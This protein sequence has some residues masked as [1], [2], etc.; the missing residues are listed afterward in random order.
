MADNEYEDNEQD[1]GSLRRQ[2][3]AALKE[4][5]QFKDQLSQFQRNDAFRQAGIDTTNGVGKLLAKAYDGDLEPD[6]IKAFAQ[7]NGVDLGG[8]SE[9]RQT[10]DTEAHADRLTQATDALRSSSRPDAT[11]QKLS[12][13]EWHALNARDTAAAR[14]AYE[15]GQV[16]IPAEIAQQLA[17]NT[18][19]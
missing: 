11:G 9:D 5:K 4:N 6:A 15:A 17:A 14:Q 12:M 2:L 18:G 10:A 13:S 19:R 3:E 7:E 16:E 1:G 8:E